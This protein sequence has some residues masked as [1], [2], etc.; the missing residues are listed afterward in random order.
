MAL[1]S[2]KNIKTRR[3]S[4]LKKRGYY[5]YFF[6]FPLILGVLLIFIPNLFTTMQYSVS[7]LELGNAGY[8][9]HFVGFKEYYNAWKTDAYFVPYLVTTLKDLVVD[10]PVITIFSMFIAVLLSTQFRGRGI[11]RLIFFI[12]VI[13]STGII[14]TVESSTDIL[15]IV[16]SGEQMVQ[17]ETTSLA[18]GVS[19]ML[20]SIQFPKAIMDIIESAIT[21]IYNVVQSSGMQIFI[22]LAGL[23]EIPA[24]L[25]EAAEVEGCNK[26]EEFWKITFP[27]V[28]PQI[29]VSIIYTIV[30][31]TARSDSILVTYINRL[32]FRQDM[33]SLGTAMYMIYMV[34]VLFIVVVVLL[35]L[36]KF[37]KYNGEVS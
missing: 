18:A 14:S 2:N 19:T 17:S 4:L 31:I 10:V 25:Y 13:L 22:L 37:I 29:R 11:A 35:V 21:G 32:A 34:A 28:G 30:D 5:G 36:N 16:E 33:F 15:N 8:T 23:Q 6:I 20:A 27:M 12:P 24:S 9:A 26:W 1:N 3:S 7:E